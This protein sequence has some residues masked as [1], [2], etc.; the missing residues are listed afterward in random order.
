KLLTSAATL[1]L[2][3][4]PLRNQRPLRFTPESGP[5]FFGSRVHSVPFVQL[6]RR[7]FLLTSPLM[8]DEGMTKLRGP[9]ALPSLLWPNSLTIVMLRPSGAT[10]IRVGLPL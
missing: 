4:T 8:P 3:A 10:R 7:P 2:V 9:F 6:I 5:G 1:M